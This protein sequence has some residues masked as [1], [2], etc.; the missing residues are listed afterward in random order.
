MAELGWRFVTFGSAVLND[1]L[2]VLD[3][4]GVHVLLAT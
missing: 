3:S 4:L 1:W 2:T